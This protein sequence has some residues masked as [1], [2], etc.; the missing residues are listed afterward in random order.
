MTAR[1][2]CNRNRIVFI[3]VGILGFFRIRWCIRLDCSP[4]GELQVWL[5]IRI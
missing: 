2:D 5:A 4:P 1:L 3:A